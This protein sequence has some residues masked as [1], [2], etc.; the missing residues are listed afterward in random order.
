MTEA[1]PNVH[2]NEPIPDG[3]NLMAFL[4]ILKKAHGELEDKGKAH[5]RF[6]RVKTRRHAKDYINELMP[7]LLEKREE[8][9]KGRL[10]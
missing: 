9:R 2:D 6:L 5:D 4:H 7:K 3:T 1:S 8:R 10:R